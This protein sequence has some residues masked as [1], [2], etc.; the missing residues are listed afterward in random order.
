VAD[1]RVHVNLA[2]GT[3][4]G[5]GSDVGMTMNLATGVEDHTRLYDGEGTNRHIR[6]QF[7]LGVNHGSLVY[8]HRFSSCASTLKQ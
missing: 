2:I 8:R 1:H 5:T 7:G 3:D 4:L 6:G